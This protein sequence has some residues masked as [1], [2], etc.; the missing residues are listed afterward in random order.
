M[1]ISITLSQGYDETQVQ[2][3]QRHL[4][5]PVCAQPNAT[6]KDFGI[7]T[8]YRVAFIACL[9]FF[10][11]LFRAF[12]ASCRCSLSLSVGG[13][14]SSWMSVPVDVYG[15]GYFCVYPIQGFWKEQGSRR[16]G[17]RPTTRTNK[18]IHQRKC[19]SCI[20][21]F[22]HLPLRVLYFFP[23]HFFLFVYPWFFII[24]LICPHSSVPSPS[25]LSA[26]SSTSFFLIPP[27]TAPAY[28]STL[29]LPNRRPWPKQV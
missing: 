24:I 8:W 18:H 13:M 7:C 15:C 2:Q 20:S 19:L 17:S 21:P 10:F 5:R 6:A 3:R 25:L 26:A 23:P 27:A 9:C 22:L 4:E 11:A 16:V 14:I 29:G 12:L 28:S 1:G